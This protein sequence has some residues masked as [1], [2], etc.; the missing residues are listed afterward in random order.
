MSNFDTNQIY[1]MNTRGIKNT[2]E[3]LLYGLIE[4]ILSIFPAIKHLTLKRSIDN[5]QTLLSKL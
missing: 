4:S 2:K 5:V 1:Y 3:V